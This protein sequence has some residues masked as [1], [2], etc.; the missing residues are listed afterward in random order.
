MEKTWQDWCQSLP[1]PSLA[2]ALLGARI[3]VGNCSGLV[4]ETEA[5]LGAND[6]AAHTYGLRHTPRN[7][8]LWQAPGTIYVYQMRQYYLLNF[9]VQP[10]G[11]PECLL[12]RA[13]QPEKGLATMAQRRGQSG[14]ALANGPGKLTQA[15]NITRADDQTTLDTGR[16]Q[17][18]LSV[19][20]PVQI[21]CGPRIGVPNKGAA[22]TAPLRFWVAHNPYVSQK[23]ARHDAETSARQSWR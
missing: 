15:L 19:R 13:L 6:R 8:A 2:Q 14:V 12:I 7:D 4:V 20:Q 18:T 9:N 3:Q 17:L 23:G 11:V 21:A 16:L 22:T 5:Y 1:T 10:Q